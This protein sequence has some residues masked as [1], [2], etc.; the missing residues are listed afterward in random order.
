MFFYDEDI[1]KSKHCVSPQKY[2]PSQRIVE[3]WRYNN[4]TFGIGGRSPNDNA[5]KINLVIKLAMRLNPGPGTYNL[6]S[7]FDRNRKTK[8]PLN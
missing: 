5:S 3:N 4:I 2:N 8:I 7:V 6:P 1:Q